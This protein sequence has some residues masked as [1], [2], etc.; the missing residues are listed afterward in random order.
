MDGQS[1]ASV[2]SPPGLGVPLLVGLVAFVA[3][4]AFQTSQILGERSVLSKAYDGQNTQIQDSNKARQQLEAIAQ[5]T[6][7][8]AGR[9]NANAQAIIAD[10]ARQGIKIDTKK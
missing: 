6:A 8:L 9:G 2:F 10:F 7:E 1:E 5:K 3:F 4:L